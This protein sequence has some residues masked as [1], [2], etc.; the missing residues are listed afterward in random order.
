M[1]VYLYPAHLAAYDK[2]DYSA[3]Q[4]VFLPICFYNT[5]GLGENIP[6]TGMIPE[7]QRPD[8]LYHDFDAT[9]DNILA[10]LYHIVHGSYPDLPEVAPETKASFCLD[11]HLYSWE[12]DKNYGRYTVKRDI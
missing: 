10:C 7:N 9:E 5:N 12:K 1:Y 11:A 3:L 4:Y 6:D 8:D 2:G